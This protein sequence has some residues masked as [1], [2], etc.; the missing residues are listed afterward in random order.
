MCIRSQRKNL[1]DCHIR[2][3]MI[4]YTSTWKKMN[5]KHTESCPLHVQ[6]HM[7]YGFHISINSKRETSHLLDL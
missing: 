7:N 5:H 3:A 6:T 4:F 2:P 1:H